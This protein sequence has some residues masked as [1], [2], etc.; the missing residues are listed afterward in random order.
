MTG[1]EP[2]GNPHDGVRPAV[3]SV[4]LIVD[5][6]VVPIGV[7]VHLAPTIAACDGLSACRCCCSISSPARSGPEPGGGPAA[8]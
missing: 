6:C 8:I 5:L 2:L 7:G 4:M 3:Q 1:R